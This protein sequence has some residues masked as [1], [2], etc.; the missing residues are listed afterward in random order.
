[1]YVLYIKSV[2]TFINHQV[3]ILANLTDFYGKSTDL[4]R[5]LYI[6]NK[7]YD[8]NYIEELKILK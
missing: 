8:L 4:L 3:N 7:E 2:K 1:M 5:F 6:L